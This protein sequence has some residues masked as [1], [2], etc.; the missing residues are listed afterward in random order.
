[1]FGQ[2]GTVT[3]PP[4]SSSRS[5]RLH[6]RCSLS[7]FLSE[8]TRRATASRCRSW[9]PST[10]TAC[11][12]SDLTKRRCWG[13]RPRATRSPPTARAC[14]YRSRTRQDPADAQIVVAALDITDETVRHE[15][16]VD[17]VGDGQ[18]EEGR[19]GFGVAPIHPAGCSCLPSRQAVWQ[20]NA[21]L[22]GKGLAGAIR[23]VHR[24]RRDLPL[25]A[26]CHWHP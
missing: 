5:R 21:T 9:L 19:W 13:V 16:S 3:Q 1:M 10:V 7:F 26:S 20:G 17:Y 18:R 15:T 11:C 6:Q 2:R 8:A 22:V 25:P 24:P 23:V 4:S 14:R 12:P